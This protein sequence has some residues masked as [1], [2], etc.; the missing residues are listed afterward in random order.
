MRSAVEESLG[1]K[2]YELKRLND[3]QLQAERD[4][5]ARNQQTRV[6]EES[7]ADKS[8]ELKRLKEAQ[9]KAERDAWAINQA[10]RVYAASSF[11]RAAE[12]KRIDAEIKRQQKESAEMHARY[13]SGDGASCAD[14]SS[15]LKKLD[16]EIRNNKMLAAS[17][18]HDYRAIEPTRLEK[19]KEIKTESDK[20]RED[21]RK[22]EEYLR[23]YRMSY[24]INPF[25]KSHELKQLSR[26]DRRMRDEALKLV[27]EYVKAYDPANQYDRALALR[28]VIVEDQAQR[29]KTKQMHHSCKYSPDSDFDTGMAL[30]SQELI[31]RKNKEAA[32]QYI[33][34]YRLKYETYS[35]STD[36][37]IAA[38]REE[39]RKKRDEA[40]SIVHNYHMGYSASYRHKVA[41]LAARENPA[42]SVQTLD[43]YTGREEILIAHLERFEEEQAGMED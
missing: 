29:E 1:D 32:Q 13:Q 34:L 27:T 24:N 23:Q 12:L 40:R 11:D 19:W 22:A 6:L 20:R 15:D 14:I 43:A 35:E 4:A 5:L 10:T 41:E 8:F 2:S 26:E 33:S 9:Q 7:F 17:M 37:L 38:Q 3:Q 31:E 39:D 28:Q 25:D 30:K 36:A 16:L 18:H 42:R 21:Q